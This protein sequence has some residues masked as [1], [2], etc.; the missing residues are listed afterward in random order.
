MPTM[1][2]P[3]TI[4]DETQLDEVMSRGSEPLVRLVQEID[5]D[6]I[7]LGIAG[8]IG[9]HL[10]MAAVRAIEKAGVKKK[11]IGVSRF[12]EEGIR[13]KLESAGIETIQC[14]LLDVEAVNRLPSVPNVIFMAGKKFGT[15][16]SEDLTWAMNTILPANV[17]RHFTESR[18]VVFSTGNVYD[19]APVCGAMPTEEDPTNPLG[20]YAQSTLGRERVFEYFCNHKKIPVCIFRLNYAVD[21]RYG[22]LRDIGDRV[23]AGQ[24]IDL[25]TGHVNVIWQGDV[26]NQAIQCLAQCSCPANIINITG[27]ETASVR[28]I[29]SRFARLFDKDVVFINEE[30]PT[31]LLNNA[32]K[33]ANLFGYP[34]VPLL[35]MIEWTAHW[36]KIGGPSLDKPTH[37]E[38]R[39]GKF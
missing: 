17:A 30:R 6:I 33:A 31:A 38:V 37:F 19:L 1:D 11:V 20:E 12:S 24:P 5:G 3:D 29:A 4:N 10:G 28:Y 36:I 2:L 32:A 25:S 7:I 16:G 26:V 18:I 14:D 21:L 9:A 27:P 39:N 34:S 22:V 35:R 8:K 13:K 15:R 23:F